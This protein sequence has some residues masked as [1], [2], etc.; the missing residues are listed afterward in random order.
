MEGEVLVTVAVEGLVDEAALQ[1][2]VTGAGGTVL[3]V[4]GRSGNQRLRDKIGGYAN[5]SRRS[6]WVVLTDLDHTYACAAALVADWLPSDAPGLQLRVAVRAVEAWLL[7]DRRRFASFVG[8]SPSR[9]P[10]A[11]EDVPDPKAL[12]VD[13]AR[14]SR[15]ADIRADL[16]PTPRAGV[17]IG[18]AYNARLIEFVMS[19]WDPATAAERSD[20]LARCMRRLREVCA[21]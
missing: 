18:R 2:L 17:R 20:S 14:H 11:P 6:P 5:A 12:V 13:L 21:S 8:V 3:T 4:H 15:R 9:L 7:A 10:A 19:A 16:V 1:R